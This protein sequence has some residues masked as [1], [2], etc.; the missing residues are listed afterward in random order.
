[1]LSDA[2]ELV[3]LHSRA[4]SARDDQGRAI[5]I[6]GRPVTAD[7]PESKRV[8]VANKGVRTSAIVADVRS[9]VLTPAD[10]TDAAAL[11]DELLRNGGNR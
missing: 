8:W 6:D 11:I 3:A 9:R 4:E 10:G 2:W 7:T 1:M 5:D